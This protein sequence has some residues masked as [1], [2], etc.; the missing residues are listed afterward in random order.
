[1][2]HPLDDVD[3]IV[4]RRK[5]E[6]DQFYAVVHPPK[7]TAEERDIQRQALAGMLWSKQIYIWDVDLWLE[8]DN[9]NLPPPQSRKKNRNVRGGMWT[10]M[11]ILAS[12]AFP[13][14]SAIIAA[15][16]ASSPQ[17]PPHP[18]SPTIRP[19]ACLRR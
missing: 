16:L 9:P 10:P 1:M 5:K 14:A 19:S 2:D 18:P 8:G 7:A 13:R 17:L 15:H 3:N 12:C 11:R 6:A 4:T